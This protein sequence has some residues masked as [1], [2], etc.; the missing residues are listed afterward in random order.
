MIQRH[1]LSALGGFWFHSSI[2]P[3]LG[4]LMFFLT[5]QWETLEVPDVMAPIESVCGCDFTFWWK[6]SVCFGL[7]GDKQRGGE[8]CIM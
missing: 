2:Y 1:L 5:R 7:C 3:H 4:N 8:I 6:S